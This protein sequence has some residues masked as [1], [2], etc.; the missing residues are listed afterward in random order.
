MFEIISICKGGGYMYCR[1]N[2]LH[3]RANS[4]GLYPLH[5]VIV[6]NKINRLLY[7]GEDVHHINKNKQ[8]NRPENLEVLNKSEHATLHRKVNV[9]ELICPLCNKKFY[10]K[11]YAY[12]LRMKRNKSKLVFCSRSCGAG[13]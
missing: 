11:P 5:R 3:P 10:L 1:T 12:N 13:I 6:E 2:P 9:I 8:D 4:K 7:F